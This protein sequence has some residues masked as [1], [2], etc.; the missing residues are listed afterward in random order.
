MIRAGFGAGDGDGP[1]GVGA[2]LLAASG[3]AWAGAPL[4]GSRVARLR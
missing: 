2:V 1:A 4:G 3:G